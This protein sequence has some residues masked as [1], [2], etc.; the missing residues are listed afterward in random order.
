MLT[1]TRAYAARW[2]ILR[3]TARAE[4]RAT[5]MHVK[6]RHLAALMRSATLFDRR[7][8]DA[9]DAVARRRWARLQRLHGARS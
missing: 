6:L 5:P 2:H 4:L 9:E 3:A 7:D 8:L 1:A